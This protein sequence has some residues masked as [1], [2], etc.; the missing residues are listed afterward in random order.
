MNGTTLCSGRVEVKANQSWFSVCEGDFNG[1]NAEV[2]CRELGCGAPLDLVLCENTKALKWINRFQ[3]RGSESTLLD[4]ES[5]ESARTTCSPIG[6]TCSGKGEV[7]A[8][9]L[10]KY[11]L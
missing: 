3:C 11:F 4:C 7:T 2:V 10:N 1:Q 9:T 6:L 8:V 5:Y